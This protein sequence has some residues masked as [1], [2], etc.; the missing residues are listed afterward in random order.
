MAQKIANDYGRSCCN[1]GH[2]AMLLDR[3]IEILRYLVMVMLLVQY[4]YLLANIVAQLSQ[5]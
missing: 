3:P 4:I 5:T 2:V 1:S